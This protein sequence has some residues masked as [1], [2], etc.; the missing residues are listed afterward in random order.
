MQSEELSGSVGAALQELRARA[1]A[2]RHLVTQAVADK[3]PAEVQ[4]LVQELQVHQIELE[5]QYE[6]LLLAQAEAEAVRAQYV[7]LYEFA[8]VGYCTLDAHGLIGQLNL[9]AARLLGAVRQRLMHRRFLLFVAP[10]SREAFL[11]FL[12]QILASEQRQ[13]CELAMLH[14][15]GTP[16]FAQLEGVAVP[17][18]AAQP[19]QCRLAI[20]DSTARHE[21]IQA[22]AASE[23]RFRQLFEQSSDASLLVQHSLVIDCN[24]AALHLL[25]ASLKAQVVGH[26]PWEQVVPAEDPAL[27]VAEQFAGAVAEARRL[28]S[29]RC[30]FALRC[31]SGERLWVECVMTPMTVGGQELLYMVWRDVTAVEEQKRQLRTE[32]EFSESLLDNSVDGIMA[33]DQHGRFLAWNRVLEQH[34]GRR[35]AELLGQDIFAAFPQWRGQ[36]QEQAIRQVLKGKRVTRYNMPF[37]SQPGHYE[38]YLVPLLGPDNELKGGLVL[39]RDVTERVRLAEETTR[40]K[41]RQQQEVLSTILTTQEEER[42][43]IAEAL[44]NGVGQLL[45]A[46]KLNLENRAAPE[47]TL[48]AT[49]LSLLDDAI[50]ATRT[51][52]F[53]LTPGILEDFGLKIALEEL[54]KRIPK[55]NLRFHLNLV[56]LEK[57]RPRP[58][59]IAIYRVVQ[60]LLN[61]IIR[62]ARASE[63]FIHVIHEDQHLHIS[64]EDNGVGI[65]PDPA[66]PLQGIGLAGIR[67]RIDL[68]GGEL[69]IESRLGRGTIITIEL[70]ALIVR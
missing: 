58:I 18:T 50:R 19:P 21:A 36:P 57:P 66:T 45:Y 55:Q 46:A 7:D 26:R 13:T 70:T 60:E 20:I 31:L 4:R 48:R 3:S 44:H 38:S 33:F 34:T 69:T 22:L 39:V 53:E 30:Q 51:I 24:P 25:G 16:F 54:C 47:A 37:H 2:R 68:L 5:M 12:A 40:L 62:H 29:E 11:G 15:D 6:E 43:R 61:N 42:K 23:A 17:A 8:P 35:A 41:L 1:E 56:G 65:S 63:V 28:G 52:S 67:N 9:S 49:A 32:K 59:E 64:V 14:D 27:P 10:A